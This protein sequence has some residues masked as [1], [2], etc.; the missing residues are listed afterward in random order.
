[1]QGGTSLGAL[2]NDQTFAALLLPSPHLLPLAQ[3][4]LQ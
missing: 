3:S 2:V 4:T 1:M